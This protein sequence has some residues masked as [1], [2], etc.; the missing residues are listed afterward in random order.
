VQTRSISIFVQN[1]SPHIEHKSMVT[2]TMRK[3]ILSLSHT[4][5]FTHRTVTLGL[6]F[7]IV[8]T[9]THTHTHSDSLSLFLRCKETETVLLLLSN[10]SGDL[11][12]SIVVRYS[13]F[14]SGLPQVLSDFL[15]SVRRLFAIRHNQRTNQL[16]RTLKCFVFVFVFVV[17]CIV[18]TY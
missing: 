18:V 8:S 9:H 2:T 16:L 3:L 15:D 7:T 11:H 6:S 4:K 5:T 17:E 12:L 13:C 14:L 1:V 10:C